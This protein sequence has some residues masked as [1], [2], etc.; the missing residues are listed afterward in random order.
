MEKSV[1]SV[2]KSLHIPGKRPVYTDSPVDKRDEFQTFRQETV[3]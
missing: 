3:K 1:E 2:N